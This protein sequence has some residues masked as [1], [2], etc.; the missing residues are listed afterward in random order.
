MGDSMKK[1]LTYSS[2]FIM[3]F[4]CAFCILFFYSK[5]LTNNIDDTEKLASDNES[6]YTNNLELVVTNYSGF[7]ISP[8]TR[9][10]IETYYKECNHKEVEEKSADEE[11]VNLNEEEL[12]EKYKDYIIKQFGTEKVVLYNEVNGYC[13]EHYI[14]KEN[15]GY[16]GVLKLDSRGTEKFY[17]ATDI[18]VQYLPE[19]DLVS[20]KE[21]VKVYGKENLNKILEDYE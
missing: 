4:L 21:G 13:G 1:W 7:K 10:V 9:I 8:N 6:N 19:T 5:T 16:I 11:I 2:V 15:N 3:I 12:Q 18:S 17:R 20:I 14:V